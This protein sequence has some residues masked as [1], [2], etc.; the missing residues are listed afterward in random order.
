MHDF[1]QED[2]N[3]KLKNHQP[4]FP[5]LNKPNQSNASGEDEWSKGG[6]ILFSRC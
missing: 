6:E 5:K 1:L 2:R 3:L 4:S